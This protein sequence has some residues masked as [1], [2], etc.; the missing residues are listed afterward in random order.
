MRDGCVFCDYAG[1]SEI[2]A[3]YLGGDV[4]VIEPINPVTEGHVLVIPRVHI[5]NFTDKP[6]HVFDAVMTAARWHARS[7]LR[8][9]NLITSKGE[10]ATQ[11]VSHLHVH[12]VPRRKNDGLK[13]PW[14]EG[15]GE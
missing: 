15:R 3:E 13:L 6:S 9:C 8:S 14:S 1:P 5:A 11:T 10:A 12:L 2:I 4:F 7:Y